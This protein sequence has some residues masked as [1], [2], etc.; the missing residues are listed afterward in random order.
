MTNKFSHS[1][2]HLFSIQKPF[3]LVQTTI[4]IGIVIIILGLSI[5]LFA[6]RHTNRF[7]FLF[8]NQIGLSQRQRE[9]NIAD[10]WQIQLSN[11]LAPSGHPSQCIIIMPP[12]LPREGDR[13]RLLLR[14]PSNLMTKC[15]ESGHVSDLGFPISADDDDPII[16]F[17]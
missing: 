9:I 7:R 16:T 10:H 17:K 2:I 4:G 14:H 3:N 8:W 5:C 11:R 13:G 12:P 6:R 15:T 1:A